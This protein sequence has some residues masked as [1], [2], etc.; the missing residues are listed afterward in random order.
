M[1]RTFFD[2]PCAL[3]EPR[4]STWGRLLIEELTAVCLG[5]VLEGRRLPAGP[6]C[7]RELRAWAW[8]QLYPN[9]ARQDLHARASCA[10][11]LGL[12]T[13]V[14]K[15]ARPSC[16]RELCGPPGD[17]GGR[18]RGGDQGARD[19][20]GGAFARPGGDIR[21]D[22]GRVRLQGVSSKGPEGYRSPRKRAA[23]RVPGRR[24]P[25][26]V[27]ELVTGPGSRAARARASGILRGDPRE[28]RAAVDLGVDHRG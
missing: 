3:G 7:A 9:S 16:A 12:D 1:S 26:V 14:P 17:R 22:R 27:P 18:G 23:G 21:R 4:P 11:V 10:S 13:M 19:R 20:F 5:G 24:L 2:G 28:P 8:V 15:L 6:S 25:N